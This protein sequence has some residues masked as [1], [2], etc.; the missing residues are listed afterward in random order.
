VELLDRVRKLLALAGSPNV[1]EAAAAASRAQAL[2]AQ[3]QLEALLDGAPD[4]DPVLDG[5]LAEARKLRPW[6]VALASALAEANGCVAYT[7]G[8]GELRLVGRAADQEAVRM[9]WDWLLE[10]LQW[11]SATEGAGRS[12]AWHEAFRIGAADAIAA[13]LREAG[14]AA[15]A[16]VPEA[17]L[18]RLDPALAARAAAVERYVAAHLRLGKGRGLRVDARA[19]AR[20]K[21]A[22]N[23]VPLP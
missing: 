20:G 15:R 1:H 13:R 9:L 8:P 19:W 5:P 7:R 16:A 18:V 10:R 14:D 4:A 22:G 23:K 3:H 2:I 21:A 11:A 6:K 12:R 17:S